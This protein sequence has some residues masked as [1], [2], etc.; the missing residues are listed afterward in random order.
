MK[1]ITSLFA[2]LLIITSSYTSTAQDGVGIGTDNPNEKAVLHIESNSPRGLLIPRYTTTE[3]NT[4]NPAASADNE[5]G[6]I[7]YNTTQEAFN[8]WNGT[9]WLVLIPTPANVNLDLSGFKITNLAN[10]TS[11][12]DAV[13][14]SQLDDLEA[15]LDQKAD[16]AQPGWTDITLI[17]GH[18]VEEDQPQ[19]RVNTIGQLEFRG[20]INSYSRT[21]AW[22]CA[23]G[24]IPEAFRKSTRYAVAIPSHIGNYAFTMYFDPDGSA[25]LG[26]E[27]RTFL[28][29]VIIVGD[30]R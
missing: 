12:G 2:L 22:F 7:I 19:F 14:K 27:G 24:T 5:E 1:T 25:L 17:N 13:N 28:N 23:A 15:L 20:G 3:R 10:G 6:L 18:T 16:A 9:E 21:S 26:T 8:Y 29:G 30:T 4:I 11:S